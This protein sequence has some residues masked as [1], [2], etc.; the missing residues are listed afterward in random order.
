MTAT[1]ADRRAARDLLAS[2][3]LIL[4][5][6]AQLVAVAAWYVQSPSPVSAPPVLSR[7]YMIPPGQAQGDWAPIHFSLPSKFGFSRTVHPGDPRA[8]TKLGPRTEE[9]RFLPRAPRPEPALPAP[10]RTAPAF[11]P[12]RDGTPA[13][14]PVRPAVPTGRPLVEALD[15]PAPLLPP[16]FG[17]ASNWA[18]SGTWSVQA[19]LE[20]GSDGRVN[21]VFLLPPLP[22]SAVS[23]RLENG[24]RVARLAGGG[25]TRIRITRAAVETEEEQTP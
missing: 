3:L 5:L 25:T 12:W 11:E 10:P 8:A 6:S 21:R 24:L 20:A 19:R 13:Y 7:V 4:A 23:A 22:A 14:A 1:Y 17:A 15:G 16:E 2:G 9:L 18:G